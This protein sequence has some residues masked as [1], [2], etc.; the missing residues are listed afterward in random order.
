M[1]AEERSPKQKN[2]KPAS[3]YALQSERR[4]GR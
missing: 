1:A 3:F 4:K 2:K